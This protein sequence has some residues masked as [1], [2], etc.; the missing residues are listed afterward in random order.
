VTIAH[1]FRGKQTNRKYYAI[2]AIGLHHCQA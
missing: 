1:T 2:N